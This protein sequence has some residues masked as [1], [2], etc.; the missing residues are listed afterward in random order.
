MDRRDAQL[1]IRVLIQTTIID[2]G[3]YPRS[4]LSS[5]FR[6]TSHRRSKTVHQELRAA[7]TWSHKDRAIC[8][9]RGHPTP[10]PN[11]AD[12]LDFK[13]RLIPTPI[14]PTRRCEGP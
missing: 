12:G 11:S 7:R 10:T 5:L 14:G 4:R 13:A 8:S 6:G 1:V 2:A 3:A 9:D